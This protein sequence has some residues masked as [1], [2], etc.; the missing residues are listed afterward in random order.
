[1]GCASVKRPVSW[2]LWSIR[3]WSELISVDMEGLQVA[4][5]DVAGWLCFENEI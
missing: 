4:Y 3:S 5:P 1:M 2:G